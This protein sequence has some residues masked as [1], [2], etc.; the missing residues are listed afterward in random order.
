MT[1]KLLFIP[2]FFIILIAIY[3]VINILNSTKEVLPSSAMKIYIKASDE[4]SKD[5]LQVNWKYVAALDSVRLKKDFS[6]ANINDARNI[7]QNFIAINNSHN[8][9]KDSKY[10]LLSLEQVANK[11]SYSKKEKRQAFKFV[12]LLK[13]KYLVTV[14]D[15]KKSFIKE[16]A[17][18]AIKIYKDYDILPS[19]TIGQASLESNWGRSDLSSKY[20]NLFGI[21]ATKSWK[22]KTV[23]MKTSENYK[24]T[25]MATFRVYP[26]KKD[27]LDDYAEFLKNNKRYKENGV[28]KAVDYINQ[29]KTIGKAGYSTKQDKA[30]ENVYADLLIQIIQEYNLQLIDNQ[31]QQDFFN[32]DSSII[33]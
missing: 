3:G 26:S 31:V 1:K 27:S 29:A 2:L 33:N 24:N 13:D 9:F 12:G 32:I 21:K 7:A 11:L 5:K 14:D 20:N 17:P 8:K 10:Q 30:G 28:F 15:Y 25:V 23:K 22:G 18:E 19:I 6:K 16:L 4:V